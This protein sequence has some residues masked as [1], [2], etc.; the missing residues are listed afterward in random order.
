M[1]VCFLFLVFFLSSFFELP[2]AEPPEAT[3]PPVFVT[4]TRTETP[5][6]QVTTSA[7]V[8]TEKD[9]QSLQAETVLQVLRTVPGLDVVQSGSRGTGTSVFI[10]GS[11]S[12]HVLVLI[13]GVEVNSTTLGAF[14]F[15]HLTTENVERIEILRGAGGTLYGS[16]AIGGVINIITKKGQGP[17]E[18]GLSLEGGK[19]STHRQA[20]TLRGGTG[21]LAYSF[22][23]ARMESQGFHSV[24]DDYR[25]LAASARLDYQVTQDASLK[26]IFHF[27]KT[28]LGLFNNNN[29]AS[30][31][32]PNAREVST[33]YLGKLEWEQKILKNWDYRISGSMFKEHIKDS[34]DVDGCTFFSFPCDSRTR[35]RFRPRIDTGEFQTNYRFDDWSTTTFGVEYKRRSASTSG[36]IDRAIRNL[37]YYLQE[38]LQFFDRRLIMIPGIR[39]DDNQ[40]FGSAWTPSFSAAYLFRET[41]T[42]LKGS[43]AKGFKAPTLNELFFPPGFGCPAFGNPNLKPER[44]WELNAG[45]EQD[46]LSDRVKLGLTYFHREVKDLIEG[47]PIPGDPF[48]CFRAE[49]V[50]TARF[51]GVEWS[52]G[53]KLLTFLSVNANYTYLDWDTADDKLRRRPK[54]RGNVNLN[55]FLDRF[56][57]NLIA[58]FVGRRDDFRTASPFGDTVKP[59]YV[60]FDLASQYSLPWQIPGVKNVTLFGK[61]ENLFNKG[62]EEVDGF[63]AR[64]LNFL[65]GLRATFGS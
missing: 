63:R 62:Y 59:G 40:S 33:Q 14:N 17:L 53:I 43:Y 54:H 10:R 6:S 45:V 15:A 19:G 7:T 50:G 32:D 34:D 61:I 38:Q 29:F 22:S 24:N 47:R 27:V 1:K 18:A 57:A 46:L 39:L 12:D 20:L 60:K 25:N 31:P 37:G 44:S 56:S 4:A 28:D 8:I 65:L 52:L 5:L 36:G 21:K 30:Q 51:D 42:K 26:G 16:Q 9:I 3:L 2:A 49:N 35:D 11:E 48:G 64:P 41:G 13:D 55:Y 23:A 58:N